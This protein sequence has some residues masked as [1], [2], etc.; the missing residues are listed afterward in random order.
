M[1]NVLHT[2]G[3][4]VVSAVIIGVVSGGHFFSITIALSVLMVMAN[5]PMIIGRFFRK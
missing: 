4:I 5:L 3:I 1:E 2:A